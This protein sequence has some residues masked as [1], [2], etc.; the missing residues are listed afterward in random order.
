MVLLIH[1]LKI[2]TFIY[3]YLYYYTYY[4]FIYYFKKESNLFHLLHG[5][6]EIRNCLVLIKFFTSET[7]ILFYFK[8]VSNEFVDLLEVN[9]F[10]SLHF[11]RI[12]RSFP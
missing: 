7:K 12:R 5:F 4:S 6:T 9:N 11:F 3:I 10:V 1:G 8:L 2:T